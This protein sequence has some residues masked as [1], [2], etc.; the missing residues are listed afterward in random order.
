M[1]LLKSRDYLDAHVSRPTRRSARRLSLQAL[2]LVLCV[3]ILAV[4]AI[5]TAAFTDLEGSWAKANI[6]ACVARKLLTGYPDG[7]MKPDNTIT[8]A[9]AITMLSRL[10]I[11]DSYTIAEVNRQF[12]SL[13]TEIIPS[14]GPI[15]ARAPLELCFAADVI[16]EHEVYATGQDAYRADFNKPI[17][18]QVLALFIFRALMPNEN[19]A[20]WQNSIKYFADNASIGELYSPAVAKLYD[21]KILEGD[22]NRNFSP[23]SYVTRAVAATMLNKAIVWREAKYGSLPVFTFYSTNPSASPSPSVSPSPTPSG[24]AYKVDGVITKL[25]DTELV[26]RG[27]D[28][29]Q[30]VYPLP[31]YIPMDFTQPANKPTVFSGYHATLSLNA[32][33]EPVGLLIDNASTWV[34]GMLATQNL[35]SQ[36]LTLYDSASGESTSFPVVNNAAVSLN[37]KPDMKL[38]DVVAGNIALRFVSLRLNVTR[39]AVEIF[40]NDSG[41]EI[42]GA[43]KSIYFDSI[44]SVDMLSADN[45]TYRLPFMLNALPRVTRGNAEI[46]IDRVRAGYSG[47]ATVR[48]GDLMSLALTAQETSVKGSIR[49]IH[50][51]VSGDSIDVRLANGEERAYPLERGAVIWMGRS[52][53]GI[54]DLHIGDEVQLISFNDIVS[55]IYLTERTTASEKL[56]GKLVITDYRTGEMALISQENLLYYVNV[57]STTTIITSG[58]TKNLAVTDLRP[59]QTVTVYGTLRGGSTITASS[60]VIES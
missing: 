41:V 34:Q 35:Y 57:Q 12:G 40:A 9:E 2:A 48:G 8:S 30:R 54:S 18:K 52:E 49:G 4:T 26:L 36:A 43:V 24:A 58:G 42:R 7:T 31:L 28:G 17:K 21:L 53:I 39:E 22:E 13:V 45:V 25:N 10:F 47:V 3:L 23:E 46:R 44:G 33:D 27:F 19:T 59:G 5:P 60:I 29:L 37:G 1:Q 32:K 55:E 16:K 15:Y 56:N 14:S 38:Q 51:S 11:T 50:R 20:N 6:E